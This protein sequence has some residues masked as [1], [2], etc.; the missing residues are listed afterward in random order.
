MKTKFFVS[1]FFGLVLCSFH[2]QAKE[3]TL[4]DRCDG[5]ASYVMDL[6]KNRFEGET[7]SEQ[8]ELVNEWSDPEYKE[9]VKH[10][11]TNL[12]YTV[13]LS[14]NEK[15]IKFQALATYTAAYRDCIK[16]YS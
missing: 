3:R 14:V 9:Y 4:D 2:L 8:M 15:D 10:I 16:K 7:L 13:P 11:L 12:I 1:C 6:L 5:H